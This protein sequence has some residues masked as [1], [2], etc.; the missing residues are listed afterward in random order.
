MRETN[1]GWLCLV[2]LL[3]G[4]LAAPT[5]TWSTSTGPVAF[6]R[7]RMSLSAPPDW[8]PV[9]HEDQAS[10]QLLM[11]VHP[12]HGTISFFAA[13]DHESLD[14]AAGGLTETNLDMLAHLAGE[15][16]LDLEA[17][18]LTVQS[19]LRPGRAGHVHRP[20]TPRRGQ[21]AAP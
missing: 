16:P 3:A 15:T 6:D 19:G 17:L 9:M 7:G 14:E 1:S 18:E 12:R 2:A 13:P 4:L 5:E 20:R 8:M 10:F 11:F 21:P